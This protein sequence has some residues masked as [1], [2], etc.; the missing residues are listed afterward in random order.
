MLQSH[1]RYQRYS[2][3]LAFVGAVGFLTPTQNGETVE[4]IDLSESTPPTLT[5]IDPAEC[6][7][8]EIAGAP[9]TVPTLSEAQKQE[10]DQLE[11]QMG[12]LR[13]ENEKLRAQGPQKGRILEQLPLPEVD[14][15]NEDGSLA[16]GNQEKKQEPPFENVPASQINPIIR[17]LE[18]TKKLIQNYH[19]AYDYRLY[20]LAELSY[21]LDQ[22]KK[23][24]KRGSRP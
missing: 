5:A 10:I 2:K 19:R 22:L 18:I 21:I 14:T 7:P 11:K 23:T 1:L 17:R 24:Q 8:A 4:T 12:L 15:P 9:N 20:T 3:I 16:T 13:V 6:R